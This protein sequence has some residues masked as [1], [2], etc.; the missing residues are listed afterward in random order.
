[1][2]K[3]EYNV[4]QHDLALECLLTALLQ[5]MKD[6]DLDRITV[7][8]LSKRAGISRMTYY[9]Y[10]DSISDILS[11]KLRSLFESFV[12]ELEASGD[13]S[14]N[15][16]TIAYFNFIKK[17]KFFFTTLFSSSYQESV[18][19]FFLNANYSLFSKLDF[20]LGLP[21]N[22]LSYYSAYRISS[23]GA[24]ASEWI[25]RGM[26]ESPEELASMVRLFDEVSH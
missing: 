11:E 3:N 10:F 26:N 25:Q 2:E 7:T 19:L 21:E 6:K 8:E 4:E 15:C 20:S 18:R 14:L 16:A 12:Q 24:V 23:L 13:I 1:M 9:R 17:E 22:V 5:L